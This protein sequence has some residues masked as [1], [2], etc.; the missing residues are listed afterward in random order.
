MGNTLI[1]TL[2]AAVDKDP[3]RASDVID[4][5]KSL[6]SIAK[7]LKGEKIESATKLE[8]G[9]TQLVSETRHVHYIS[10]RV[11]DGSIPASYPADSKKMTANIT[12]KTH[13]NWV[14]PQLLIPR[15]PRK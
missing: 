10:D 5:V 13:P 3:K 15:I 9:Q 12:L 2:L 14:Y 11:Y 6:I 8:V 1:T 4:L 7:E